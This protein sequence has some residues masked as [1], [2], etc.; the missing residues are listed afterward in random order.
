MASEKG[1]EYAVRA[2][3]RVLERYPNARVLFAGPYDTVIGE[4]SYRRRLRPLIEQLGDRW[5][6][7]GTLSPEDLPAFYTALDVLLMTS[8]NA[9]ESF[10]LV[11]V[12]AMLCGTPVVATNLPGVRQ[13]V[14][15]TG[16]G[17]IV[18]VADDR[19]LANGICQV[20]ENP[21]A[22]VRP[23][24]EIEAIYSL[25]TTLDTYE[26]LYASVSGARRS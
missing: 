5:V 17:V 25:E 19:S 9:T 20:L 8:I 14:L 26:H 12:E 13:P 4:D 3:P 16:M 15:Q 22:F 10:G 11:Q 21:E 18:D 6:F 1:I 7:V 23:R 24:D 2:L